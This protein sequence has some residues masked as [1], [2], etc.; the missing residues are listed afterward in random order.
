MGKAPPRNALTAALFS[1][2]QE[3][4][5]ALLIGQPE[6]G[7]QIYDL[8]RLSHGGSGAVQRQVQRLT[9][10]GIVEVTRRGSQ[11]LYRARADCPIF[12]ELHGLI[13]KT[14]GLVEPLKQ[15]LEPL[16]SKIAFAFVFGSVAKGTER[17]GSDVDLLVVSRDLG[18]GDIYEAVIPAEKVL[19]RTIN[20]TVISPEEWAR[21]RSRP[22]SFAVRIAGQ[23]KMFVIGTEDALG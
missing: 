7:F 22:D 13:L 20:P 10:A 5:L 11:K 17:A 4:V 6:R 9:E 1:A 19:G 12:P 18:Y 2:V 15:A 3:R 14:I 8:I 23:P 21:K 16:R